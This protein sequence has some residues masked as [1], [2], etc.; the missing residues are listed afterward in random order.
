MIDPED[1]IIM[2]VEHVGNFYQFVWLNVPGDL[3]LQKYHRKNSISLSA[4]ELS[5]I[6]QNG[7]RESIALL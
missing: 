5:Y 1:E 7:R 6:E 2:A 3:I 4:L